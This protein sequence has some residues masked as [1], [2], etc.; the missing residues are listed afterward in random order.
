MVRQALDALREAAPDAS[1]I[2]IGTPISKPMLEGLG[3][4]EVITYGDG[5][6]ARSVVREARA[7]RPAVA[8]IVYW[9]PGFSGHLKLEALAFLCGSS[10]AL[11]LTPESPVSP[12]GRPRLALSVLG[13]AVAAGALTLAGAALCGIALICLRLR[14]AL[15]GG[16]RAPR[17]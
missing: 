13:K 3:V 8:A 17:A 6:G 2:A 11:R 12:I 1:I 10:R 4:D 7:G 16:H 9:G 5:R 14:Q 15:A